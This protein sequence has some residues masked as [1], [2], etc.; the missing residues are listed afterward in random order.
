MADMIEKI[1]MGGL[2]LRGNIDLQITDPLT[3]RAYY[4]FEDHNLVL[5]GLYEYL[6]MLC[7]AA[8]CSYD[9][10]YTYRPMT[11]LGS[12][13]TDESSFSGF[14]LTSV[15]TPT[16]DASR[17]PSTDKDCG[18]LKSPVHRIVLTDGAAAE[19]ARHTDLIGN[20]VA[21]ANLSTAASSGGTKGV[22]SYAKSYENWRKLYRRWDWSSANG[23]GKI[24]RLHLCTARALF[25]MLDRARS[26]VEMRCFPLFSGT[27][28]GTIEN[29]KYF[30]TDIDSSIFAIRCVTYDVETLTCTEQTASFSVRD[31]GFNSY[32]SSASYT[33]VVSGENG[34]THFVCRCYRN[35]YTQVYTLHADGSLTGFEVGLIYDGGVAYLGKDGKLIL[36]SV[37]EKYAI[38]LETHEVTKLATL[39]ERTYG[40]QS[41]LIRYADDRYIVY[42]GYDAYYF[43]TETNETTSISTRIGSFGTGDDNFFYLRQNGVYY[44]VQTY[45]SDSIPYTQIDVVPEPERMLYTMTE[46]LLPEPVT[47]DNMPMYVGYT[48]EFE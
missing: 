33:L 11:C 6:K 28:L 22:F 43:N 31:A 5:D 27:Y 40:I 30:C 9:G 15:Q 24:G 25:S 26:R 46:K 17:G 42:R 10:H 36:H 44:L 14:A 39:K 41:G 2:T 16:G 18:A 38:S 48:L 13:T 35:Y 12:R 1:A 29:R 21:E 45:R 7:I 32:P 23:N 47:K 19:D 34:T 8:L 3:G 37:Y 20:I 4:K